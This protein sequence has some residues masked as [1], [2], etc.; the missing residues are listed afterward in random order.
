MK[1]FPITCLL[2]VLVESSRLDMEKVCK[3]SNK[4]FSCKICCCENPY[5][6]RCDSIMLETESNSPIVLHL[7]SSHFDGIQSITNLLIDLTFSNVN[8]QIDQKLFTKMSDLTALTL[9]KL[10]GMIS[11]PDLSNQI[12]LEELTISESGL[13]KIDPEFC[14]T[15][16]NLRKIDFSENVLKTE[17]LA[18]LFNNCDQ[19]NNL[20]LAYNNLNSLQ[21]MFT[22]VSSL[23]L[24]NLDHN[25]IEK[26]GSNDLDFLIDLEELSIS[27]NRLNQIGEKAFFSL[28]KIKKLD[29]SRNYLESF[30]DVDMISLEMID[31]SRNKL[32]KIDADFFLHKTKLKKAVL[33]VN[34]L[35]SENLT[36]IFRSA[37]EE[38]N[39]LDLSENNLKLLKN[40][41]NESL[42]LM[43]LKLDNNKIENIT[44]NDFKNLP[45]LVHV[46]LSGNKLSYIH[47]KAFDYMSNLKYLDL[48]RNSLKHLPEKSIAYASI[49]SFYI[50]ENKKLLEFPDDKQFNSLKVLKVTYPYH[51]CQFIKNFAVSTYIET[52]ESSDY[53]FETNVN[54]TE[55]H[56]YN[57]TDEP[58]HAQPYY[59]DM[60]SNT[61]IRN[62]S[63]SPEPDPFQP[64]IILF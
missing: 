19:L 64:C 52:K 26:I 3:F 42:K 48:S 51:C 24:L 15:N 17:Q 33:A 1:K 31:L 25:Y 27:N 5:S 28:N 14:F 34:H 49:E 55:F 62:V 4:I 8:L 59:P 32:K 50:G 22:Y 43:I 58:I 20:D 23:V 35:E 44:E 40:I 21:G 2:L 61:H 47:K 9:V 11:V 13:Q 56:E 37:C 63:C 39:H 16:R 45:F 53:V 10:T 12:K 18:N 36:G 29:L 46:S 54:V 57:D 60:I 41:F 38:L 7:D 30:S 6:I